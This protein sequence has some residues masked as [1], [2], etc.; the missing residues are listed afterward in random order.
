MSAISIETD[1]GKVSGDI[2]SSWNKT[3]TS[4]KKIGEKEKKQRDG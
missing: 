1:F 4:D 3:L 2:P